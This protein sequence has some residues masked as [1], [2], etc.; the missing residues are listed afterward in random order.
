MDEDVAEPGRQPQ[1]S[2]QVGVDETAGGE[3]DEGLARGV[4]RRPAV[5]GDDVI[6]D[7][8]TGLDR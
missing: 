2:C 5:I 3:R 1:T 6:G 8:D 4:R 7:V